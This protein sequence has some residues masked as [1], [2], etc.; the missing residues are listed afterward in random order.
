M[1]KDELAVQLMLRRV[2][3]RLHPLLGKLST[4]LSSDRMSRDQPE[5]QVTL[6][7]FWSHGQTRID[8]CSSTELTHNQVL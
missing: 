7:R 6:N 1:K 2:D 4:E 3:M 8:D 5:S